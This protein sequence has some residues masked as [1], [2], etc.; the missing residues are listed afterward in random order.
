MFP[1]CLHLWSFTW[2]Q[3]PGV[4]YLHLMPSVSILKI[5]F[6]WLFENLNVR[7]AVYLLTE[8]LGIILLFVGLCCL[9][10]ILSSK[11]VIVFQHI[12]C[13]FFLVSIL[14][15]PRIIGSSDH[16]YQEIGSYYLYY[17]FDSLKCVSLSAQHQRAER[18]WRRKESLYLSFKNLEVGWRDNSCPEY[19][20]LM[21]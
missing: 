6:S 17:L 21:F 20:S 2:M 5:A 8:R 18:K 4:T 13:F 12:P 16:F 14:S 7:K 11:E 10:P 19:T 15:C 1:D 9:V 3:F